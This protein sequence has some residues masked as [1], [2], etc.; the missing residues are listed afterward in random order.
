M[1][2]LMHPS[3]PIVSIILWLVIILGVFFAVGALYELPHSSETFPFCFQWLHLHNPCWTL[4]PSSSNCSSSP[5]RRSFQP[6]GW[7]R[8]APVTVLRRWGDYMSCEL[9]CYFSHT[10]KLLQSSVVHSSYWSSS[11]SASVSFRPFLFS[12]APNILW[13]QF[14]IFSSEFTRIVNVSMLFTIFLSIGSKPVLY[15]CRDC[16]QMHWFLQQ[17]PQLEPTAINML[18]FLSLFLFFFV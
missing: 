16:F 1:T 17:M 14:W 15:L 10:S 6:R 13:L 18:I 3:L 12:Y 2:N 4:Y 11:A 9:A 8:C 7:Y 5:R